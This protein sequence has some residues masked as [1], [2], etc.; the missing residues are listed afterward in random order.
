ML[1]AALLPSAMLW[2]CAKLGVASGI[3]T[4]WLVVWWLE[5]VFA[6]KL[7]SAALWLCA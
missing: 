1:S 6:A 7:P 4:G 5:V 3:G 2:L